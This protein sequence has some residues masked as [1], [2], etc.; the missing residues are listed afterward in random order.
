MS[1]K[2]VQQLAAKFANNA[3]FEEEQPT[4]GRADPYANDFIRNI[5]I[6]LNEL[7]G[8]LM[9]LRYRDP[10]PAFNRTQF[11]ELGNFWG[12]CVEIYKSLDEYNLEKGVKE[13][14][15]LLQDKKDWLAKIIPAIKQHMK[16]T[17]VDFIPGPGL[18]QARADGLKELI[19]VIT[20]GAEQMKSNPA[21]MVL[22]PPSSHSTFVGTN[23]VNRDNA[24]GVATP[25]PKK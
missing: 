6:A 3:L 12:A 8:D 4:D 22:K 5:R 13:F 25:R 9:T 18:S 11:K 21:S 23:N 20:M 1:Y 10:S 17:E 16:N 7:E 14:V 2:K 19:K 15:S 24:T